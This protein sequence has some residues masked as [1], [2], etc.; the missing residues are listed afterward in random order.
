[1][2]TKDQ[3]ELL[4]QASEQTPSP[5]LTPNGHLQQAVHQSLAR[6]QAQAYTHGKARM[7]EAVE[8]F[9]ANMKERF[10]NDKTREIPKAD[11]AL[12]E[13]TWRQNHLDAHNKRF[14]AVDQD[15]K[16]AIKKAFN[17]ER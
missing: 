9:R 3:L 17:P 14:A 15:F 13:S 11:C 8:K 5:A 1:M 16:R 4:R 6:E 10:G 7:N 12:A 2:I